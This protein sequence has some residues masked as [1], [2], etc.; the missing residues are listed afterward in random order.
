MRLTP[1]YFGIVIC[2][3]LLE[4]ATS[5]GDDDSG[6]TSTSASGEHQNDHPQPVVDERKAP[7]GPAYIPAYHVYRGG[8]PPP[9]HVSYYPSY[10]SHPQYQTFGPVYGFPPAGYGDFSTYGIRLNNPNY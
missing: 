6:H 1:A 9:Y 8:Y 3:V 5:A 7:Y 4:P 2:L 10:D